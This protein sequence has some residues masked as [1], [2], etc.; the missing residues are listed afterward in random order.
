MWG[1]LDDSVKTQTPKR[2]ISL[3]SNNGQIL[4][5]QDLGDGLP[6]VTPHY[7]AGLAEAGS[8]CLEDQGHSHG[9]KLSVGGTFSASFE[10]YWSVVNDQM[11]RCWNDL[12]FTTEQGAYGIAFLVIRAMTDF[13]IIERSRKGTGFDY[14]LG[15][16]DDDLPFSNKARLEVSGIRNGDTQIINQRVRR[17]LEQTNV[18]DGSL[19]AYVV[20]VEFSAPLSQVKRK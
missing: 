12:E 10:V 20:V 13:T 9:V 15:Y 5:L 4:N 16:E 2:G 18:S 3:A 11:R 7:G 17:K 19:E 14:W 1:G 6:A 8:V